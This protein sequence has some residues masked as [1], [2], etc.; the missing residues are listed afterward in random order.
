VWLN[1]TTGVHTG[2]GLFETLGRVFSPSR[3]E[4]VRYRCPNCG[5]EFVYRADLRDPACPYCST[6]ALERVEWAG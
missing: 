4:A 6:D 3:E 2:M 5:R 1:T